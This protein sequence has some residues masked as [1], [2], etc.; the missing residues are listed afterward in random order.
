[1]KKLFI[2]LAAPYSHP[3]PK[4]MESRFNLI[5]KKAAALMLE[6]Y[7][8]YSP[9]S[10]G[11]P[12]ALAAE[13]KLPHTWEF[14]SEHDLHFLSLCDGLFVY[15]LP[16]WDVSVGVKAEIEFAEQNKIKIVYV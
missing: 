1:M 16:G 9:I 6:G 15:Q 5:N 14:W 12:I 2:Y 3:D 8:V 13:P 7:R 10:H 4:E 11:R